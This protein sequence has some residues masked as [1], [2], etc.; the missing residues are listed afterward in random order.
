[1]MKKKYRIDYTEKVE[2]GESPVYTAIYHYDDDYEDE[3]DTAS[4][5]KDFYNK[6]G[7]ENVE[8]ITITEVK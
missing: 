1:M 5:L 7:E 4:V 3:V 6:H 8:S 2:F